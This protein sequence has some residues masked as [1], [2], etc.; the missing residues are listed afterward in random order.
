[1]GA[2]RHRAPNPVSCRV[3]MWPLFYWRIFPVLIRPRVGYPCGCSRPPGNGGTCLGHFSGPL[4]Q[5]WWAVWILKRSC[6]VTQV[7]AEDGCYSNLITQ[8]SSDQGRLRAE[9]ELEA[10]SSIRSLPPSSIAPS[11]K[12]FVDKIK[13][14]TTTNNMKRKNLC[15]NEAWSEKGVHS[16]Q[17]TILTIH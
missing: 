5:W 12:V 15:A 9:H 14:G 6:S 1:M 8:Q 11:P 10:A 4:L 2:V 7:A 17:P 3:S 13:R 16:P